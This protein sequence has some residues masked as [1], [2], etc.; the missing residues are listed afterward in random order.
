[1]K[2][3]QNEEF[4]NLL[5]IYNKTNNINNKNNFIESLKFLSNKH[6]NLLFGNYKDLIK[7]Q[8]YILF[9]NSISQIYNKQDYIIDYYFNNYIKI[10]SLSQVQLVSQVLEFS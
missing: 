8:D 3:Y 1:M 2:Y 5:N 9:F 10:S 6:F 7:S 4:N